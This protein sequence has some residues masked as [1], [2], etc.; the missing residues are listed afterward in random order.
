[1]T[2]NAFVHSTWVKWSRGARHAERESCPRSSKTWRTPSTITRGCMNT[3]PPRT[4]RSAHSTRTRTQA[5]VHAHTHAHVHAHTLYPRD[6]CIRSNLGLYKKERKKTCR[7]THAHTH[8]PSP[9]FYHIKICHWVFSFVYL[10]N[11][12]SINPTVKTKS[13]FTL[14]ISELNKSLNSLKHLLLCP[15]V[16]KSSSVCCFQGPISNLAGRWALYRPIK[17]VYWLIYL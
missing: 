12:N 4:P 6:K 15:C 3:L 16:W 17:Y 9:N 1:M 2:T 11:N 7:H 10:C 14:F 13:L 5:H 8:A